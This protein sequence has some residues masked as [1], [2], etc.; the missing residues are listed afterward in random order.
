MAKPFI[1]HLHIIYA[2][3]N[4]KYDPFRQGVSEFT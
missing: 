1:H 2:Q 4:Y 3:F